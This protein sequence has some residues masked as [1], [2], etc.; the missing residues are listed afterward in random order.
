MRIGLQPVSL[1]LSGMYAVISAGNE[2]SGLLMSVCLVKQWD[3]G[4][5]ILPGLMYEVETRHMSMGLMYEVETRICQRLTVVSGRM[6]C[7]EMQSEWK[8]SRRQKIL[9]YCPSFGLS[10]APG[11][12]GRSM[13]EG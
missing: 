12:R 8:N 7:R 5:P 9:L 10:V 11:F 3:R 13:N 4:S 1:T 2:A 6:D